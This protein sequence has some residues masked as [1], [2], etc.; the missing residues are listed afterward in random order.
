VGDCAV[1]R[2]LAAKDRFETP[3]RGHRVDSFPDS[4]MFGFHQAL[5][6]LRPHPRTTPRYTAPPFSAAFANRPIDLTVRF[7]R[8][9][10][11]VRARTHAPRLRRGSCP[12]APPSP[13]LASVRC[14]RGQAVAFSGDEPACTGRRTRPPRK[15]SS[16]W[17]ALSRALP[18]LPAAS[19]AASDEHCQ[20]CDR[21]FPFSTA[22]SDPEGHG[23]PHVGAYQDVERFH[24]GMRGCFDCANQQTADV[25]QHPL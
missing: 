21:R 5:N 23:S 19:L 18:N 10:E 16:S 11:S 14:A 22:V 1:C 25:E 24:H 4:Q 6:C 12:W 15:E 2:T 8:D 9:K 13:W 20:A 3:D 7:P 17:A